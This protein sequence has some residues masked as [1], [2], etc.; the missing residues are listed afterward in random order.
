MV[1]VNMVMAITMSA[2]GSPVPVLIYYSGT[3]TLA[4]YTA[5]TASFNNN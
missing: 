4:V 2:P 3:A 1:P 5:T